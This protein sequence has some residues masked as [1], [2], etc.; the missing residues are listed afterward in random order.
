MANVTQV[1]C[2]QYSA[3]NNN[4]YTPTN[5]LCNLCVASPNCLWC[6][7]TKTCVQLQHSTAVYDPYCKPQCCSCDPKN[8]DCS[9]WTWSGL[10]WDL[11]SNNKTI[12][13]PMCHCHF[14]WTSSVGQKQCSRISTPGIGILVVLTVLFVSMIF[15][16]SLKS[17][18]SRITNRIKN[19]ADQEIGA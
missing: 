12:P 19:Q 8:G 2:S 13:Q 7:S 18:K 16:V 17:Y 15:C 3:S 11:V 14:F 6:E 4:V 5:G 1:T 10:N 9:N